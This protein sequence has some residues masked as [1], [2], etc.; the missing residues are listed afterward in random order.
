MATPQ[1]RV[2]LS[3]SC[4]GLPRL[5]VT[6]KSDPLAVV[7]L[8]LPGAGSTE[9]GRTEQIMNTAD[10]NFATA[11]QMDYFF[12]QKQSL[13]LAVYDVDSAS[14][15]LSRQDYIGEAFCTLGEIL[16][17]VG[18]SLTL[19]LTR[20]GKKHGT[21]TVS[22]EEVA[23]S[24]FSV[25]FQLEGSH[26]DRMDFFSKSDPF[27]QFNRIRPDGTWQAIHKTEVIMNNHYPRWK[28][29]SLSASVL[30]NGDVNRPLMIE[31]FDWDSDGGHDLIGTCQTT[32]DT[33][34]KT[35][36]MSLPLINAKKQQK[37]R[38]YNNSGTLIFRNVVTTPEYSML[39]YISA[40]CEI[41]VCASIDFTGSNGYAAASCLYHPPTDTS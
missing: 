24:K 28:T 2:A 15:S 36:Q 14:A 10:P 40:G 19:E 13:R 1:A 11:V 35:P 33:I 39:D 12:E 3:L 8:V 9:V 22:G 23:E 16:G 18:N 20:K 21:I 37:K 26:L 25:Q 17:S 31:C 32:L 27:L 5:D 4:K 30:C 29:F 7:E 41:S 38:N 34:I 6:S